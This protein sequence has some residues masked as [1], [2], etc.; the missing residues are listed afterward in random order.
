MRTLVQ[1]SGIAAMALAGSA[2]QAT[3]FGPLM[4]VAHSTW[5]AKTHIAVVADYGRSQDEVQNLA[6]AAGEGNRITV[7]DTRNQIDVEKAYGLITDRVRP[8]YLVLLP[9][10]RLVW[11]GSFAATQVVNR[12]AYKGIP[13]IATTPKAISQGAVFAIGEATGMNLLVTDKVIGTVGVI[14]PQ[15]ANFVN[16]MSNYGKGMATV[17]V[18]ASR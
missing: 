11:D 13:S 15:R 3:D 2:A 17:S 5:P 16:S 12:L 10:D 7:L 8:D 18:V 4:D 6:M 9:K 14:L 1:L